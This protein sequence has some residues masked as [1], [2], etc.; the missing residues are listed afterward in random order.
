MSEATVERPRWG[1]GLVGLVYFLALRQAYRYFRDN[2]LVELPEWA[3]ALLV[4]LF[5]LTTFALMFFI[6]GWALRKGW[7]AADRD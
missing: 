4:V 2:G 3:L 7:R 6:T 1:A 5:G